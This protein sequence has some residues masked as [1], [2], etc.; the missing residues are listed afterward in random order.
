MGAA[1]LALAGCSSSGS[2]GDAGSAPDL[3]PGMFLPCDVDTVLRVKCQTCHSDPPRSVTL[4]APLAG[5]VIMAPFPLTEYAHTQRDYPGGGGL[6]IYQVM[7][8]AIESNFMPLSGSPT[9]PL[10]P[11]QKTTMLTWLTAGAPASTAPCSTYL[12]SRE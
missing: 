2:N 1:V 12:R 7:K 8:T 10:T 11:E 9:G 4:V 3:A 5:E 6:K